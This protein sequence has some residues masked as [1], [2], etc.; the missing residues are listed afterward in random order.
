MGGPK[1]SSSGISGM[2]SG[3]IGPAG[4]STTNG[5]NDMVPNGGRQPLS[6]HQI[7]P[8]P[9]LSESRSTLGSSSGPTRLKAPYA[10][11]NQ[12]LSEMSNGITGAFPSFAQIQMRYPI[13]YR[14]SSALHPSRT[15]IQENPIQSAHV[16]GSNTPIN[17]AYNS[18][19][20]TLSSSSGPALPPAPPQHLCLYLFHHYHN[21]LLPLLWI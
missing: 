21:H 2:N 13:S 6:C 4:P 16:N 19:F 12:S 8:W 1:Y 14:T 20:S 9:R 18:Q 15:Q 5:Q 10:M 3:P 7:K 11:D 17:N